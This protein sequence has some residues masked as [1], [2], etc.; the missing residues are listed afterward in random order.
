MVL[1]SAG[2]MNRVPILQSV[3]G[4]GWAYPSW[5]TRVTRLS[6]ALW[7]LCT[8]PS[9][10]AA[11]AEQSWQY[12]GP[13]AGW[14][15]ALAVDPAEPNLVYAAS[16]SGLYKT[17]NGATSWS[18]LPVPGIDQNFRSLCI[19]VQDALTLYVA[20]SRTVHISRDGGS[21]WRSATPIFAEQ[22]T[23]VS[24]GILRLQVFA[25]FPGRV[26]AS[27]GN[28]A[29]VSADG[30]VSW[31][32]FGLQGR[33]VSSLRVAPDNLQHWLAGVWN[34]SFA[35]SADSGDGGIY[36]SV[37]GGADWQR[38]FGSVTSGDVER[39]VQAAGR[40]VKVPGSGYWFAQ[41]DVGLVTSTDDGLTWSSTGSRGFSDRDGL[42]HVVGSQLI[43]GGD[44][45][46]LTLSRDNGA[47]WENLKVPRVLF[48]DLLAVDDKLWYASGDGG[49]YKS[50]DAGANWAAANVGI[51]AA[52]ILRVYAAD[53]PL[54]LYA[55]VSGAGLLRY[56]L[57]QR[58]WSSSLV[59]MTSVAQSWA[60]FRV[61]AA[62]SKHIILLDYPMR[63][64][65]DGGDSWTRL[66]F[67][68]DNGNGSLVE[69]RPRDLA[70]DPRDGNVMYAVSEVNLQKSVDGGRTWSVS[71]RSAEPLYLVTVSAADSRTLYVLGSR[72]VR[73]ST[74]AGETWSEPV[75]ISNRM[76]SLG[77]LADPAD[78]NTVFVLRGTLRK[79]SDGGRS[80]RELAATQLGLVTDLAFDP[81]RP[82]TMYAAAPNIGLSVSRD[83][84]ESWVRITP[85]VPPNT[86]MN[87][88]T[89]DTTTGDLYVGTSGE[90]VYYLS[91]ETAELNPQN[92][93]PIENPVKDSDRDSVRDDAA[94]SDSGGGVVER[95]YLAL[96]MLLTLC[97]ARVRLR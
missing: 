25:E 44:A 14:V 91:G 29:Y 55:S 1:A 57:A 63:E 47:S 48:R 50:T 5:G 79:S 45:G 17:V 21:T 88:L 12:L 87:V 6:I 61:S 37:N 92:P 83:G 2:I 77:L 3:A 41:T 69:T 95:V 20:T 75:G 96:L 94:S 15:S 13:D 42:L 28:G 39:R 60:D 93:P 89:L 38:V 11:Q 51:R 54:R 62:D 53:S 70:L 56:D 4:H 68:I 8:F 97:G 85:A 19:D 43:T 59:D 65:H 9:W 27:T 84:G 16:S 67:L 58:T 78:A 23:M 40:I 74:D 86:L 90:G 46:G 31:Q 36:R 76:G 26:Y 30:G 32:A 80:W 82:G 71:L 24:P 18:K 35:G 66:P 52:S 7:V 49:V 22:E 72:G 10:V 33:W 64:T 73:Q 34:V 81:R